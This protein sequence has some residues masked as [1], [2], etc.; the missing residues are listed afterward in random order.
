MKLKVEV[1]LSEF[2]AEDYE[3]SF[4][5]EIQDH[6]AYNVKQK[7]LDDWRVKIDREFKEAVKEELEKQKPELIISKINEIVVSEKLIKSSRSEEFISIS[8]YLKEELK[9]V[10][11]RDSDVDSFL[12]K[13]VKETTNKI[14]KEL[15]ERYDMLF[16]SQ[17][18]SKLNENKMLK[19]DVAKLLLRADNKSNE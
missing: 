5:Q 4:S 6:I 18:V 13:H 1:D 11:L 2:Y 19:D 12:R 16:A 10:Y 15:K 9:R 3:N 8:D 7:V 14:T 17:I